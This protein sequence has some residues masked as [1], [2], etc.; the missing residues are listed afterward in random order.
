M[1]AKISGGK[2]VVQT[3]EGASSLISVGGI[4][5][6]VNVAGPVTGVDFSKPPFKGPEIKKQ[7][8]YFSH[9]PQ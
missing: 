8:R 6:G 9:L 7:N 4:T 1:L 2:G 3:S 5:V